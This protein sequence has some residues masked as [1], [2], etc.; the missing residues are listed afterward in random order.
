[1]NTK[2]IES[3]LAEFGRRI[4]RERLAKNCSQAKL[5]TESGVSLATLRRLE[6]G[7]SIALAN[8]IRVLDALGLGERLQQVLPPPAAD[9]LAELRQK[10]QSEKGLRKRASAAKHRDQ[11][12][13][14]TWGEDK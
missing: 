8:W 6:G 3:R 5:A 7:Q 2:D 4:E 11:P 9:P 13:P 1:M 12:T 14:W 10:Q